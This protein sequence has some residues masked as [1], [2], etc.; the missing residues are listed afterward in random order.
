[1][2]KSLGN[3]ISPQDLMSRFNLDSLRYFVTREINQFEDT[4]ISWEKFYKAYNANL[5]NGLGNL[6]SRIMKLAETYLDS[7]VSRVILDTELPLEDF[8]IQKAMN[9]IWEEVGKLD[10]E[11]QEKKPWE[12]KDKEV[13]DELVTKLAHIG[14]SLAPFM[15]E[16]SEKILKAI[17][18]N[19]LKEPLFPRLNAQIL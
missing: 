6:V 12:S 11:I 2:S 10:K 19:S 8:E 18:A 17:E 3:I 4:D 5:A 13:I 9:H 14:H 15:P 1:M 16:T 7:P